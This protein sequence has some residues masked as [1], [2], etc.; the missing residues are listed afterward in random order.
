M[1]E[2]EQLDKLISGSVAYEQVLSLS[3]FLPVNY[4]TES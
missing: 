3:V 2:T 1:P 4:G